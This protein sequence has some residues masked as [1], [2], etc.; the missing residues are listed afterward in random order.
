[1]SHSSSLCFLF[2]LPVFR[3]VNII[4]AASLAFFYTYQHTNWDGAPNI[5]M[6]VSKLESSTSHRTDIHCLANFFALFSVFILYLISINYSFCVSNFCFRFLILTA[7]LKKQP[8]SVKNN[9]IHK[10]QTRYTVRHNTLISYNNVYN[11]HKNY[12]LG[13]C[14]QI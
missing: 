3:L 11:R 10:L 4:P 13:I 6:Y 1:M 9:S 7:L 5:L 8:D 12:R 14:W 2:G